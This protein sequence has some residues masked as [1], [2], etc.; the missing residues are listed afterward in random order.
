MDMQRYPRLQP[1]VT[2]RIHRPRILD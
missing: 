2:G 1:H